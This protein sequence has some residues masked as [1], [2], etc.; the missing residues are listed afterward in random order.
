MRYLVISLVVTDYFENLKGKK[1]KIFR[2]A[3]WLL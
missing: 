2:N 1:V 3:F